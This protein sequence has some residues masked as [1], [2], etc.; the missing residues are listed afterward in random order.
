MK[1]ITNYEMKFALLILRSPEKD[2]N[3]NNISKELGITPMGALKIAKKLE[4]ENILTSKQLGKAT[5]YK[6]NFKS[7]YAKDFAKLLLKRELLY[8]DSFTK[9]W[10]SQLQNIKNADLVL[11]FGSVLTKKQKA[12][13]IDVLLVTNQKKFNK[14]K[15]E[16]GE[17]NEMNVKH[18]HPIYQSINDL[19]KNIKKNDK[20]VLNAIK[21]ILIKR[22]DRFL[23]VL[24]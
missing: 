10:A 24:K 11:L 15:K 3:A 1:D 20:V 23:E 16:I 21:G 14:L 12:N 6:F 2:Y 5:F 7:D 17:L 9:M 13:D 4:K 22:E 18:I 19:K 8:A